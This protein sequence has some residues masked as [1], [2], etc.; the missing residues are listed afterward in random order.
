M[1]K[2]TS[3]KDTS[4]NKKQTKKNEVKKPVNTSLSLEITSILMICFSILLIISIFFGS[5][6]FLGK[7]LSSFFKGL[8]GIGAYVLPII[9][10]IA[11][12]YVFFSQAKKINVFK[13]VLSI[14]CFSLFISFFHIITR[15]DISSFSNYFTYLAN[16][17]KSGKFLDGG[18]LGALIGDLFVKIMGV[19]ASYIICFPFNREIFL[20]NY[21]QGI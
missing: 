8:F 10:I 20:Y 21:L 3:K 4:K 11:S 5:G 16:E 1:A 7:A 6:S 13:L 2:T 19:V 12:V 15:Q 18:M 9:M 14:I 17:Y